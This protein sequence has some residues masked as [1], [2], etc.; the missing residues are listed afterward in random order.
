MYHSPAQVFA[1]GNYVRKG[2]RRVLLR[3][4]GGAPKAAWPPSTPFT[5]KNLYK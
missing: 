5:F 1:T 4:I 2:H 3:H